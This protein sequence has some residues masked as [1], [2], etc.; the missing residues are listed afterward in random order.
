[1]SAPPRSN[2]PL[3]LTT[4]PQFLPSKMFSS[5]IKDRQL[6]LYTRITVSWGSNEVVYML[7]L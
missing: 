1:M 5:K 3:P 4:L 2:F 7:L 6:V